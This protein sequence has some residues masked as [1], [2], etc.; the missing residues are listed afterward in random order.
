MLA[1]VATNKD[2]LT[3]GSFDRNH[4]IPDITEGRHF[5][6][7]GAYDYASFEPNNPKG[8][9]TILW[10]ARLSVPNSSATLAQSIPALLETGADFFGQDGPST[11]LAGKLRQGTVKIGETQVVE[12]DVRQGANAKAGGNPADKSREAA[13]KTEAAPGAQ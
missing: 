7:V 4:N 2:D 6:L 5:I 13:A 1:L 10:R 3:P 11:T 9:R 8:K 12:E